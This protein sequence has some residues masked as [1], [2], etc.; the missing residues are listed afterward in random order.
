MIID[1]TWR[2]KR[3]TKEYHEKLEKFL[4]KFATNANINDGLFDQN[5]IHG[6][7]YKNIYSLHILKLLMR[8]LWIYFLTLTIFNNGT[9]VIEIIEDLESINFGSDLYS[10]FSCVKDKIYPLIN[11][12]KIID[13]DSIN[14]MVID[15]VKILEM[16]LGK[17]IEL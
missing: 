14:C 16:F 12:E 9:F 7:K 1:F 2:Y 10:T 8:T 17:L 11:Q 3:H 6:Y 5:N 15:I 4:E 13:K